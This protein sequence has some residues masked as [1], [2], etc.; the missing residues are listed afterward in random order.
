MWGFRG[1]AQT[2]SHHAYLRLNALIAPYG[3]ES[4]GAQSCVIALQQAKRT[5]FNAGQSFRQAQLECLVQT[6]VVRY[7]GLH[8]S[9]EEKCHKRAISESEL[10]KWIKPVKS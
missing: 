6:R 7:S 3:F 9:V 2:A 1:R 4:Y 10:A 5:S 8:Y